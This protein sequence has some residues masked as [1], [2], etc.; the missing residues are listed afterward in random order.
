MKKKLLLILA[1]AVV[2]CLVFAAVA[3]DPPEDP[4]QPAAPTEP[5]EP[6]TPG[7]PSTPPRWIQH[8][9]RACRT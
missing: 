3:C 1:L 8:T 5:A 7:E 4:E 9:G 2:L 6:E